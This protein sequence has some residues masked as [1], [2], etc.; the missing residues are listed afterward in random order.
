MSSTSERTC[1]WTTHSY[2][3]RAA[4][5]SLLPLTSSHDPMSCDRTANVTEELPTTSLTNRCASVSLWL[6][7]SSSGR[8]SSSVNLALRQTEE[9]HSGCRSGSDACQMCALRT[10]LSE[11]S[12]RRI[13]SDALSETLEKKKDGHRARASSGSAAEAH[14]RMSKTY[15]RIALSHRLQNNLWGSG[16]LI[17]QAWFTARAWAMRKCMSSR[18]AVHEL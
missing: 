1:V 10:P 13:L 3:L 12:H 5:R 11:T 17:F 8:D 18:S 15:V 16:S 4:R 9:T 14:L 6:V 7:Q 2:V